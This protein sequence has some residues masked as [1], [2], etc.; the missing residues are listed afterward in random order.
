MQAES[1]LWLRVCGLEDGADEE[2]GRK[3]KGRGIHRIIGKRRLVT[4][5]GRCPELCGPHQA[6][7][8][9]PSQ[10]QRP[11]S[12][13]AVFPAEHQGKAAAVLKP[14]CR[15]LFFLFLNPWHTT[16]PRKIPQGQVENTTC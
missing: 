9:R 7:C 3:R 15:R 12:T 11:D 4:T 10:E 14:N 2:G 6:T 5:G 13:S 16:S 1:E 8:L